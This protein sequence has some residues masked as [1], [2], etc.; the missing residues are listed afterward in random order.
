MV[1]SKLDLNGTWKARGFDWQHGS[2]EAYVGPYV[3]ER[4]FMDAEVPGDI[5]LDLQRIGLVEDR[6]IGL[7]AQNQ[8]WVEEQIWVYRR[9]FVAPA[10]AL[11]KRAWLMFEALDLVADIYLNGEKIG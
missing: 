6:N 7:N 2:P 8:R 5:H 11:G 10:D 9:T 1:L 3:S 4:V